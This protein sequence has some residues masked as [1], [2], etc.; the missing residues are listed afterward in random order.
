[1]LDKKEHFFFDRFLKNYEVEW[2]TKNLENFLASTFNSYNERLGKEAD[3]LYNAG[4]QE[5]GDL[6]LAARLQVADALTM[7]GDFVKKNAAEINKSKIKEDYENFMY[8]N[9]EKLEDEFYAANKFQTSVRGL[10]VRGA[11][12]TAEEAGARAKKLQKEDPL[13]NIFMAAVG[14][15]IPWDPSPSQIKEQE[16]ANDELNKLM[17]S[18]NENQE[19]REEFYGRNPH[20]RNT[21][22]FREGGPAALMGTESSASTGGASAATGIGSSTS[23]GGSMFDEVGDLVLQR[24]MAQ[25]QAAKKNA[26]GDGF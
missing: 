20:L 17:K 24:K 12:P 6:V 10:K 15:W 8:K 9:R 19:K 26:S 14:K 2:K 18:Y 4:L 23:A 5:Q 11:Y 21:G 3:K 25:A 13:H 7:Y 16:Y 22:A 1:V